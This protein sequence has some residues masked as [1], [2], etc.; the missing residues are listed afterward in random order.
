[1]NNKAV[2]SIQ[3]YTSGGTKVVPAG[4]RAA[5]GAANE[6]QL[7]FSARPELQ[8]APYRTPPG[9]EVGRELT[10]FPTHKK[11]DGL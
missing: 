3:V 5:S 4:I 2:C 1:M 11:E 10:T 9:Q 6:T 8:P 7:T